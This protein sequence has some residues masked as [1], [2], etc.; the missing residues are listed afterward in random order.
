MDPALAAQYEQDLQ[1]N[2]FEKA[3]GPPARR[4]DIFVSELL[5]LSFFSPSSR[6]LRPLH[7]QTKM[8]TCEGGEAGAQRQKSSFI[9]NC[10]VMSV[11]QRVCH[12]IILADQN[13]CFNLWDAER[14]NGGF[15]V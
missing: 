3:L 6:L 1:V 2:P 9:G 15:G 4:L 12:F 14:E 5:T 13:M 10:P 7:C 11:V 8:M